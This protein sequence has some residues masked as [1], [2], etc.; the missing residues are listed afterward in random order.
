[1]PDEN[2]TEA[3]RE[4][5]QNAYESLFGDKAPKTRPVE[6]RAALPTTRSV[7]T[8]PVRPRT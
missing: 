4:D 1:M 3:D 6:A 8:R 5:A 2:G 7:R